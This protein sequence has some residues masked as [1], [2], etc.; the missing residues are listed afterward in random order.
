MSQTLVEVLNFL[1]A[2]VEERDCI[3]EDLRARGFKAF[4][5]AAIIDELLLSE[6]SDFALQRQYENEVAKEMFGSVLLQRPNGEGTAYG[7]RSQWL[8]EQKQRFPPESNGAP[9]T[10]PLQRT[11]NA[12]AKSG[13][14]ST[15]TLARQR[16]L[17]AAHETILG[18]SKDLNVPAV[19]RT[20]RALSK[21]VADRLIEMGC[22]G[23]KPFDTQRLGIVFDRDSVQMAFA[24]TN[25]WPKGDSEI[26]YPIS[27]DLGLHISFIEDGVTRTTDKGLSSLVL[28]MNYYAACFFEE[29][30]DVSVAAYVALASCL[31]TR[32]KHRLH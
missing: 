8:K 28:G 31:V 10:S 4:T 20:H 3:A 5:C 21:H 32:V 6:P 19:P 23:V 9:S 18:E 14:Q 25:K 17:T 16:A 30:L 7:Y 27:V 15:L 24:W 2:M 12:L 1:R 29:F 22:G 13:K 11:M 26:G